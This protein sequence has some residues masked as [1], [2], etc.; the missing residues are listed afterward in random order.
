VTDPCPFI[1]DGQVECW[2]HQA[3]SC[4]LGVCRNSNGK[5]QKLI[6][7]ETDRRAMDLQNRSAE[8]PPPEEWEEE[9]LLKW[10]ETVGKE[11]KH[12]VDLFGS[13][14]NSVVHDQLMKDPEQKGKI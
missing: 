14:A 1:H 12:Y 2:P 5:V 10:I 3:G 7:L 13:V 8:R 4:R 9:D 11:A 6:W